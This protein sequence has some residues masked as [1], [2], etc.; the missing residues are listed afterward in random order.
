MTVRLSIVVPAFDEAMGIAAT[1]DALAPWRAAGHEVIVADG[2]SRDATVAIATPRADRLIVAPRGRA[3]QMNAGAA[4]ANGDVLLFLHADSRLPADAAAAIDDAIRAGRRW[5]RF[6]VTIEG[7]SRMLP[8]VAAAMNLRSRLTGIATGD[9]GIFVER[10]LFVEA[11][12][13]PPIPL[14]EDLAL[15]RMLKRQAGRP[16]C[17][18]SRIRT[19]GRRWDRDGAWRTILLMWRLRA[20][21]SL[22]ADPARLAKAY[23]VPAA[24]RRVLQVFAK[25]PVP[26]EVKTRLARTL[27]NDAAA[28]AYRELVERTLATADVARSRG[29]VA[30]VE[31]WCSPD[32]AHPALA[33]WSRSHG[34]SLHRQHGD[35]LGARMRGAL[36][37]ALARRRPAAD[38]HRLPGDRRRLPRLGLVRARHARRRV[39]SGR[40]RRL[41]AR[42][43]R[44]RR[45][46]V[47]GHRVE[48]AF[49]HARDARGT[50]TGRD[51]LG[52]TP[53][54]V[55]RRHRGRSRSLARSRR[56]SRMTG[57]R[58]WQLV[59]AAAVAALVVAPALAQTTPEAIAVG[60]F[61]QAQPGDPLP[62][63]WAPLTFRRIDRH[64]RYTL[65]RDDERGTVVEA[66]ADASASGLV[67]KLDVDA[68]A[69]PALAWSW[70]VERP[71]AKGDVT[72]KSGDDYAAR[73]YVTFRVPPEKL[74]P[75]ERMTRSAARAMFGDDVPD[76]GLAYI[77]DSR[78]PP[79]TIVPNPYTDRVRMI[80][81][82]SG[83][84]RAGRWLSYER[85]IAADYR[86]AFGT[87][88]PPVS[89]VAIMTDTDNTGE[90]VRA[91]YGDVALRRAG[92]APK[93]EPA[94]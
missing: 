81:V 61:S 10:S 77:W 41:R 59:A 26:G 17:L 21:W 8:I 93:P 62:A 92:A 64:T 6:D 13:F 39:R 83:S 5:G 51:A 60:T 68:K 91:W 43:S 33:E 89:G 52:G 71:V 88:P 79:G 44:A 86:A 36:A 3:S 85:D 20:A 4:V 35:D 55:G 38:R 15:S 78:A 29:I 37:S 66:N 34:A 32:V 40:G 23:G 28:A 9:Q 58:R 11:G 27:G 1:L 65:V 70:K 90:R 42:R 31:L 82:E 2:G 53:D 73:V 49:G 67:R 19:S 46:R 54:A 47:H 45:R 30:E 18:A 94:R 24:R 16:A 63:D 14:M 76:T 69:W 12:G 84:S 80:V 75:F 56:A 50:P 72:R 22:G 25:A 87:D 48:H 57:A 7:R 74:S